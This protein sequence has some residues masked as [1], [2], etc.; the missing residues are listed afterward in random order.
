[1]PHVT[2]VMVNLMVIPESGPL[3]LIP[4]LTQEDKEI[5]DKAAIAM[6]LTQAQFMRVALVRTAEAVLD[7]Q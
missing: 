7:Q 1:M 6:N 4:R 3:Q 2:H 5:I